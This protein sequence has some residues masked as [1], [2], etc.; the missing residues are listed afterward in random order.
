MWLIKFAKFC[1]SQA[2]NLAWV[3][4]AQ[5]ILSQWG[6]LRVLWANGSTWS[7]RKMA[8]QGKLIPWPKIAQTKLRLT[9]TMVL[10]R[11]SWLPGRPRSCT[12]SIS[13]PIPWLPNKIWANHWA[14]GKWLTE[15]IILTRWTCQFFSKGILN[16]KFSKVDLAHRSNQTRWGAITAFWK[17]A[18]TQGTGEPE[19]IKIGISVHWVANWA[20]WISRWMLPPN[21]KMASMGWPWLRGKRTQRW[22]SKLPNNNPPI[23][24][25]DSFR[26]LI[27]L[28][29][30][31]CRVKSSFGRFTLPNALY[32]CKTPP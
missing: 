2:A 22:K 5:N 17:I 1:K 28:L 29:R 12:V 16:K 25:R 7:N 8:W 24:P 23:P 3:G 26:N 4:K 32:R 10:T 15:V 30:R 11:D 31:N 27:F 9:S 6:W 21:T 18:W 13:T 19:E 20:A 14:R